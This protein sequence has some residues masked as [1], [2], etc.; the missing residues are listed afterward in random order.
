[1]HRTPSGDRC[2][3]LQK[4]AREL[5]RDARAL[6]KAARAPAACRVAERKQVEANP[7]QIRVMPFLAYQ[8]EN[9]YLS[10]T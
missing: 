5:V 3:A 7:G 4:D 8:K 1:M 9:S 10:R 2:Q 6:Q